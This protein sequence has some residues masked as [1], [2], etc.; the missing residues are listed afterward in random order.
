M[1]C[2]AAET[3]PHRNPPRSPQRQQPKTAGANQKLDKTWGQGQRGYAGYGASKV[4]FRI[5]ALKRHFRPGG[6]PR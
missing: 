5:A 2:C 6:L 3:A 1:R 4:I